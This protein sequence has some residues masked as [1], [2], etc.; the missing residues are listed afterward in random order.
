[1]VNII[2]VCIANF[3]DY[4]ISNVQQLQR[5]G[6]KDIYIL[7]NLC[8]FDRFHQFENIHLINVDELNDSYEFYSKSELDKNFRGGF[9][10]LTSLRFFYIYECMK[11]YDISNVIHIE[12][13]VLL[14]YHC[15]T[16][17]D[18]FD[19]SY[20][21]IPFDT[22]SR[23]IASIMYI[24]NTS[25]F[26]QILD[27]YDF[28]TTDMQNFSIIQKQTGL[29]R[30]LPIFPTCNNSPEH[31]FVSNNFD[32]FNGFIFDAAAIGQYLGGV[33]PQNKEGDT[34]G[35]V[36]ETCIIKY[37]TYSF[38]WE[39]TDENVKKP[40]IIIDGIKI[41]IFNLHIHCKNLYEF[42]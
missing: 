25:V 6:H 3:Q 38:I 37:N 15:N 9:W 5:L 7:T 39:I 23:N 2:L 19:S 17:I 26:K 34:T 1:M 8:F 18:I 20:M 12:N 30:N 22:F 24:P 27:N 32:I 40:F 41:P 31:I 16:I 21:Y 14:Y 13:D 42:M 28:N 33:D 29:I 11:K 35:F 10:T 36:N 4:I